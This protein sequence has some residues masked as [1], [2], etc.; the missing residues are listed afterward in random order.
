MSCTDGADWADGSA[1]VTA[2]GG[3]GTAENPYYGALSGSAI[4][5]L[6]NGGI[7]PGSSFS[8]VFIEV[9]T[10][11]DLEGGSEIDST[12]YVIDDAERYG[13]GIS[14]SGSDED[15]TLHGTVSTVGVT[16]WGMSSD[17]MM[18]MPLGVIY[19][20]PEDYTPTEGTAGIF[21]HYDYN[22]A[23]SDDQIVDQDAVFD[24]LLLHSNGYYWSSTELNI[25]Q[26]SYVDIYTGSDATVDLGDHTG[27][28]IDADG[29]ITGYLNGRDVLE[30]QVTEYDTTKPLRITPVSESPELEFMSDP[31]DGILIPPN[32]HLVTFIY[33][34]GT[35]VYRVVEHGGFIEDV[36]TLSNAGIM[37]YAVGMGQPDLQIPIT[38]DFVFKEIVHSSGGGS[39]I[40]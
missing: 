18:D 15:I 26:G 16:L 29:R 17:Y 25:L 9:G 23:L 34:D 21:H 12:G 36:P 20:V 39:D 38:S 24:L 11:L 10:V 27:L 5:F 4:S 37:W 8:K 1:T 31:A 28:S 3:D 13:I 6:S 19:F 32:H 22:H 2:H 7:S 33:D 14:T 35:T 30:L 40:G